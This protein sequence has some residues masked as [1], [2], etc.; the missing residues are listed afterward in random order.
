MNRHKIIARIILLILS[1]IN[2]ALAAPLVREIRE[3]RVDVVDVAEDVTTTSRK[4]WNPSDKWSTNAAD[5]TNMPSS[6]GPSDSDYR[7]EQGLRPHDPRSPM[8]SNPPAQQSP[9]S[10]DSDNSHHS[11][12]GSPPPA[13][14]NLPLDTDINASPLS[15]PSINAEFDPLPVGPPQPAHNNLPN[16]VVSSASP[17]PIQEPTDGSHS[18]S[19]STG[20]A[21]DDNDPASPSTHS[22]PYHPTGSEPELSSDGTMSPWES[23]EMWAILKSPSSSPSPDPN[24]PPRH[25]NLHIDLSRPL[26]SPGPTDDQP[27]PPA[28]PSD[29]GPSTSDP[30]PSTRPNPGS[31]PGPSSADPGPSTSHPPSS[32]GLPQHDSEKAFS[33]LFRGRFKRRIPLPSLSR[34]PSNP[35]SHIHPDFEPL[36]FND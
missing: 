6:L 32:P 27:P 28:P 22:S 16:G 10:T 35:P 4:Y 2:F 34:R 11:P 21:T 14:N 19:Q 23:Y 9:G 13:Q 3:V 36:Q 26:S 29:P 12:A 20:S 7:L 1:V 33:E 17:Q 25:A 30:G 15:S 31:D 8:D 18:G 5:R 24:P